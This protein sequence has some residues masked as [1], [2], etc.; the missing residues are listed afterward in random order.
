MEELSCPI[1]PFPSSS[2]PRCNQ[3]VRES[4]DASHEGQFPRQREGWRVDLED[5]VESDQPASPAG[6]ARSDGSTSH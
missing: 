1:S 3:R 2:L 5:N 6:T 4:L